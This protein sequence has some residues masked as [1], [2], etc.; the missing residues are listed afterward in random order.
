MNGEAPPPASAAAQ[1]RLDEHLSLLRAPGHE[2]AP[3]S[4]VRRVVRVARV[5]RLVRASLL[6]AGTIAAGVLDGIAGMLGIRR[7]SR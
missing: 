2:P 4:L 7:G 3:T 5:Q 6:V 1:R